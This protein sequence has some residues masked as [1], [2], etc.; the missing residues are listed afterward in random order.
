MKHYEKTQKETSGNSLYKHLI[1]ST[2]SD[3]CTVLVRYMYSI[4]TLAKRTNT[5][6]ILY[7]YCTYARE[8]ALKSCISA[9]YT[10]LFFIG[11][12]FV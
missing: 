2:G 8:G 4:C 1:S 3:T 6:H 5:V 11:F 10:I 12:L 7:I 9:R